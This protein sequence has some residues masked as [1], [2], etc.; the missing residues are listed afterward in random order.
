M[1]AA[2]HVALDARVKPEHDEVGGR[3]HELTKILRHGPLYHETYLAQGWR[4]AMVQRGYFQLE[5]NQALH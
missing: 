2:P 3:P 4:Q 5:T 1:E